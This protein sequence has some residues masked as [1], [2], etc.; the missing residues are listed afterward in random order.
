M[1]TPNS[2]NR[3]LYLVAKSS[4]LISNKVDNP[5]THC[6][7]TKILIPIFTG[8]EDNIYDRLNNFDPSVTYTSLLDASGDNGIGFYESEIPFALIAQSNP[9]NIFYAKNNASGSATVVFF[10][11]PHNKPF[12]F[13]IVDF[14]NYTNGLQG[15]LKNIIVNS[16]YE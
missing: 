3:F 4:S 1:I 15:R 9:N 13:K 16:I 10:K 8:Q 5:Q 12:D 6:D 14:N 7:N 2:N 11:F